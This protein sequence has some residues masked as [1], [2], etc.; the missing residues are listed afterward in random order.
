MSW[1]PGEELIPGRYGIPVP[2]SGSA[3]LPDAIVVPCVGFN[4][5]A[6]RLGYGGG[7]FDRTLPLLPDSVRV[8]GVAF[9][10]QAT[11]A[12]EPQPHDRPMHCIV[13][14]AGVISPVQ[15]AD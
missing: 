10:F 2:A 15:P 6:Y 3:V 9:G 8:V 12:F 4:R 1:T 13:T 7:W 5:A 11:D 14:E